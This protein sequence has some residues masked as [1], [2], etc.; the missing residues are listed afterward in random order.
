[1]LHELESA[2]EVRRMI[3]ARGRVRA[4]GMRAC[5]EGAGM[6]MS[7]KC[8]SRSVGSVIPFV[9]V[10]IQSGHIFDTVT[11]ALLQ[12]TDRSADAGGVS[13]VLAGRMLYEKIFSHARAWTTE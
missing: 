3:R 8:L 4:R 7:L 13:E 11:M 10:C 6:K 1:M 12:I 2:E 9:V 5:E